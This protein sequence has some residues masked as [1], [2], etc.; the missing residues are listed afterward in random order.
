MTQTAS[1]T[2]A[3]PTSP[4]KRGRPANA[5]RGIRSGAGAGMA[6]STRIV[7]QSPVS[8]TPEQRQFYE[9]GARHACELHGV[10]WQGGI[11]ATR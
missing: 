9:L 3:T 2:N 8:L 1:E 11:G 10:P 5:T 7:G 4:R 6:T